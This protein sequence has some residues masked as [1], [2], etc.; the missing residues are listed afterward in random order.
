MVAYY[1]GILMLILAFGKQSN[2]S[3]P[4][5]RRDFIMVTNV[6]IHQQ[7]LLSKRCSYCTSVGYGFG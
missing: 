5:L 3:H 4:Y 6:A 1:F 7:Q 2:F